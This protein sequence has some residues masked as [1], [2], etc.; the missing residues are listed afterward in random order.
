MKKIVLTTIL[1]LTGIALVAQNIDPITGFRDMKWGVSLDEATQAMSLTL[2]NQNGKIKTFIS[3]TDN[4]EIGTV[5]LEEIY[6]FFHNEAGFFKLALSGNA[7]DNDE[8]DAI[9]KNRLGKNFERILNPTHSHQ[10]WEIGDV[11]ANFRQQRSEDF[12]LTLRSEVIADYKK[13]MNE[14]ISD[15]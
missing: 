6:Y 8:M 4:H 3:P 1:T 14:V 7:K 2:E 12:S 13:E 15:F 10:I 11:T 9:L 5:K